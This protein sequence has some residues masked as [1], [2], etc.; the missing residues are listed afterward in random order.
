VDWWSKNSYNTN[1][2]IG[3]GA[4]KVRNNSDAAW[5]G[6]KELP[7][8]MTLARKTPEI[9]G[10]ILFSAKSLM[11]N[12]P[13]VVDYLKKKY[14]RLPAL[15]PTAINNTKTDNG[16][17]K[18]I[19]SS[20]NGKVLELLFNGIDEM[21]YALIYTAGRKVKMGYPMKKLEEKV[22]IK[23]SSGQLTISENIASNRY[24]AITFLDRYGIE[25]TPI[26]IQPNKIN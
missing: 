13:D 25:S 1:L 18:L 9:S 23:G 15:T 4:Y 17:L 26:L 3:N 8:Q 5:E 16:N 7:N 24:L 11:N 22:N 12:N 21:S 14:Y 19:S 2:Y 20:K 6:K 10:N